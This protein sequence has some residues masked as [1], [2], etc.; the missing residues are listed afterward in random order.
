MIIR[1]F[2]ACLAGLVLV[3]CDDSG[4]DQSKQ[5]EAKLCKGLAQTECE[6]KAECRWDAEKEKCRRNKAEDQTPEAPSADS[7][8]ETP[9]PAPT[10]PAESPAPD[11]APAPETPQ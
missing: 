7:P 2:V 4:K 9:A 6:A 10:P 8:D 1:V 3:G 5:A 11:E